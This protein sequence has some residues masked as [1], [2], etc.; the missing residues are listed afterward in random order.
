MVAARRRDL[1]VPIERRHLETP[2]SQPRGQR[3]R[4]DTP[5]AWPCTGSARLDLPADVVAR[6]APGGSVVE[7][8]DTDHCRLALGAW[9]WAG[10]AGILAPFDA[11]LTDLRPPELV[12]AGR[13]LAR[14][15]ATLTETGDSDDPTR[16]S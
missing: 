1:G 2:A 11:E 9:S 3:D 6:W 4:G 14:R 5:A 15:W 12:Q 7:H 10:I 13:R 8:L 16:L